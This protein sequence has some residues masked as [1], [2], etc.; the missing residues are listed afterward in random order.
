M[1]VGIIP[2]FSLKKAIKAGRKRDGHL[3][4]ARRRIEILQLSY[5]KLLEAWNQ[6]TRD[7][8]KLQWADGLWRLCKM[9]IAA[10]LG[11]QPELDSVCCQNERQKQQQMAVISCTSVSS[12]LVLV[13]Q[14]LKNIGCCIVHRN[15][16]CMSTVQEMTAY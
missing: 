10:F 15:Q 11:D 13:L 12:S 8:K 9:V 1:V 7:V 14:L 6:K 2:A 16:T 3:G 5:G 4:C